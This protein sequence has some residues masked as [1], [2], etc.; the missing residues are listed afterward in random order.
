[1]NEKIYKALA[2]CGRILLPS[3]SVLYAKLGDI[4]SLPYT[5]QIPLT[6]TALAVFLNAILQVDSNKFFNDHD[7]IK[8]I[9]DYEIGRTE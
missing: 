7:I 2:F 1:M 4:W 9:D 3:L 8:K 6:L 5:E